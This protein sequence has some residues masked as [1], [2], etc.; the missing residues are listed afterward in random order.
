MKVFLSSTCY[1][2]I[3]VRTEL[4]EHM[5]TLGIEPVLSDKNLSSFQVEPDKNSIDLC[6]VNVGDC[7]EL[8][9]VL[10]QRYGPRLGKCG[11]EDVSATHL[12]YRHAMEKGIP[13]HVFVR[14]RLVADY[15][16]WSKNSKNDSVK[17]S[18]VGDY[19]KNCGLF[20][21]LQEHTQLKAGESPNWYHT[22]NSSVDLKAAVANIFGEKLLPQ[23]L[24]EAIQTNT[25]PELQIE[26]TTASSLN[27][28][29][30]R[31]VLVTN[32]GG[33]P[34]FEVCIKWGDEEVE[35][36]D[37]LLGSGSSVQI[38][39]KITSV[40]IMSVDCL[41]AEYKSP[42]GIAVKA[43]YGFNAVDTMKKMLLISEKQ[44]RR[45][46]PISITIEE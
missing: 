10:D 24:V 13:V 28:G 26:M 44:Y 32:V 40:D 41:L 19:K 27:G 43:K 16:V 33:A 37:I 39:R 15:N 23:R 21:L 42:I 31:T 29:R 30:T 9:L 35:H 46:D 38:E 6:L 4:Y 11:F 5:R 14:D 36:K 1:D 2:L 45:S 3:D 18:W 22:F 7:S 20:E 12:E 25:F 17:F 8:I 34:A